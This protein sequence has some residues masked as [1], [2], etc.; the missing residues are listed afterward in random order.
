MVGTASAASGLGF[1]LASLVSGCNG[2]ASEL[3]AWIGRQ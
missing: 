3:K 1:V 2:V